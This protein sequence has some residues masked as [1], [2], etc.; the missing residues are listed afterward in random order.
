MHWPNRVYLDVVTYTKL[1]AGKHNYLLPEKH[2][3]VCVF[4]LFGIL[5][6]C[7]ATSVRK[8]YIYIYKYIEYRQ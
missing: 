6:S 5:T 4:D 1:V 3:R 7:L 8:A 2:N